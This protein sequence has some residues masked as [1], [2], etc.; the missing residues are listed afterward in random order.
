MSNIVDINTLHSNNQIS[1]STYII[2]LIISKLIF[3][4]IGCFI[5]VRIYSECL[6]CDCNQIVVIYFCIIAL[7][8]FS[9]IG[10]QPEKIVNISLTN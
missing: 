2:L 3:L 9:H 7:C 10:L 4:F 8:C 1:K 6:F 5:S